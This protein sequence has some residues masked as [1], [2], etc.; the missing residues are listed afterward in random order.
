MKDGFPCSSRN[1]IQHGRLFTA[2]FGLG[3]MGSATPFALSGI[4][5]GDLFWRFFRD[6]YKL[7]MLLY[8]KFAL[9]LRISWE[10]ID[11]R[12]RK[13]IFCDVDCRQNKKIAQ[14]ISAPIDFF[15]QCFQ[16]LKAFRCGKSTQCFAP[17]SIITNQSSPYLGITVFVWKKLR[18]GH[19]LAFQRCKCGGSGVS[20]PGGG[21]PWI[22]YPEPWLVDRC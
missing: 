6:N 14:V 13:D 8:L 16:H 22:D 12:L 17:C 20:T 1:L 4:D 15:N 5:F 2:G 18:C 9:G 7:D 21:N 3:A 19:E 10:E 11:G